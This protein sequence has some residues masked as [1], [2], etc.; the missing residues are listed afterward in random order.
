MLNFD[1]TQLA[2]LFRE[3]D[4]QAMSVTLI[5]CPQEGVYL[6]F[7]RLDPDRLFP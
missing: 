6:E 1:N 5:I 2:Q 3:T 4:H 7:R